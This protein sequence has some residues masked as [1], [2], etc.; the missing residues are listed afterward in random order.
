[1]NSSNIN[2]TPSIIFTDSKEVADLFTKF[3]ESGKNTAQSLLTLVKDKLTTEPVLLSNNSS[4]FISFEYQYTQNGTPKL[5]LEILETSTLFELRLIKSAVTNILSQLKERPTKEIITPSTI[6]YLAFGLG[7]DLDYWSSFGAYQLVGAESFEDFG[8]ARKI[9]LTFAPSMGLHEFSYKALEQFIDPKLFT[10]SYLDIREKLQAKLAFGAN[11][12]DPLA[13]RETYKNNTFIQSRRAYRQHNLPFYLAALEN[14]T[15]KFIQVVYNTDNVLVINPA[16]EGFKAPDGGIDEQ[17]YLKPVSSKDLK[18]RKRT[19]YSKSYWDKE[20]ESILSFL[21][22]EE[23]QTREEIEYAPGTP[24]QIS[25]PQLP[26][27]P[28]TPVLLADPNIVRITRFEEAF[29]KYFSNFSINFTY[30]ENYEYYSTNTLYNLSELDAK[31][32]YKKELKRFSSLVLI[33]D[34]NRFDYESGIKPVIIES[35]NNLFNGYKSFT[36]LGDYTLIRE[37]DLDIL[38]IL[39]K[40]FKERYGQSFFDPSKPLFIFGPKLLIANQIYG[41]EY[42]LGN[43]IRLPFEVNTSNEIK[44]KLNS[45]YNLYNSSKI[46]DT[47]L[48]SYLNQNDSNGSKSLEELTKLKNYPIFKYNT[49]NSNVLSVSVNDNKAYLNLLTQIYSLVGDYSNIKQLIHNS[50]YEAGI[51]S[52]DASAIAENTDEYK[53][54]KQASF[55]HQ[56][57]NAS[58]DDRLDMIAQLDPESEFAKLVFSK[59]MRGNQADLEVARR[60]KLLSDNTI[61]IEDRRA[62]LNSLDEEILRQDSEVLTSYLNSKYG[63]VNLLEDKYADDPMKFFIDQMELFDQAVLQVEIETLPYFPISSPMF[64]HMPCILLANRPKLLLDNRLPSPLDT[65]SGVYNILGYSHKIDSSRAY[66]TFKLFYVGPKTGLSEGAD[67]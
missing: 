55:S 25:G 31:A 36:G 51:R 30:L 67:K 13:V 1:M 39:D 60:N 24:V 14:I 19:D 50:P 28:G 22:S 63:V 46:S 27:I 48:G 4:S 29:R 11:M 35:L 33:L 62:F 41:Q 10:T 59:Y 58:L 26:G 38:K 37:F 18:S 64:F 21:S 6:Y 57:Y 61:P 52:I 16:G 23:A 43:K 56:L 3:R 53:K 20:Y 15:E 42:V 66:S 8:D 40:K 54:I 7:N 34:S 5:V 44:Q 47:K 12:Q 65:I 2:P 17:A 9:T 49:K 32:A 45:V